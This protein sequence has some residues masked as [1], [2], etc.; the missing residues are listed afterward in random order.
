LGLVP[1]G[2]PSAAREGPPSDLRFLALAQC[3]ATDRRMRRICERR[4]GARSPRKEF[5]PFSKH[6]RPPEPEDRADETAARDLEWMA[7]VKRGD[8]EALA[9]LIQA[10]QQRVVLTVSKMLGSETE[11]EDVA[12]KVFIRVWK[13][14]PPLPTHREVHDMALQDHSQPG[15]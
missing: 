2:I 14:A 15:P 1:A 11:A 3:A 7:R 9:E 4:E 13:S 12:L 8:Q 5:R 10:Q 6:N